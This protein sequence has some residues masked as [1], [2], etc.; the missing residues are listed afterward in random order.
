MRQ[1]NIGIKPI[2]RS[3]SGPKSPT[4]GPCFL[5]SF[6]TIWILHHGDSGDVDSGVV[7]NRVGRYFTGVGHGPWRAHFGVIGEVFLS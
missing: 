4:S 3:I 1:I 5:E 7:W 6:Q 2:T